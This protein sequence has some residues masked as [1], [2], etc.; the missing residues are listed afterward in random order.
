MNALLCSLLYAQ[1]SQRHMALSRDFR[2]MP[3]SA[4]SSMP[5]GPDDTWRLAGTFDEGP[6]DT[7][8]SAGTFDECPPLLPPLCPKV[9]TT[10]GAKPGLSTNA[11]LCSL[12]YAQ[13]SRRHMALSRDF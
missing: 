8:R 5:K 10:H 6:D 3:S 12:L 7:W 11:L 13:R 4:P 1:R 2:R 9:P